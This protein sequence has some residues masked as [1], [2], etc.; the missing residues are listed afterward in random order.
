M[1][2]GSVGGPVVIPHVYNGKKTFSYVTWIHWTFPLA[3]GEAYVN[4]VTLPSANF[5]AGNFSQLLPGITVSN[6]STGAPYTNNTI[7]GSGPFTTI[8]SV[9][10]AFQSN[11]FPTAPATFGI[12]DYSNLI[13]EPEHINR[14]NYKIDHNFSERSILGPLYAHVRL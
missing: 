8:S 6:P 14:E 10:Q 5:E 11:Y 7:S 1:Y 12:D 4:Q 2:G 3:A 13:T 9:A